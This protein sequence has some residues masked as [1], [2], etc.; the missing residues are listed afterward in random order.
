MSKTEMSNLIF[1]LVLFSELLTTFVLYTKFFLDDDSYSIFSSVT[2]I[3][4]R[5]PFWIYVSLRYSK[6]FFFRYLI[7]VDNIFMLGLLSIVC[8]YF[9][10]I[11][12]HWKSYLA[13]VSFT[14]LVIFLNTNFRV[15]MA[16]V[17]FSKLQLLFYKINR[18][19]AVVAY[20]FLACYNVA[21]PPSD[22][23]AWEKIKDNYLLFVVTT[24][25]Y[26]SDFVFWISHNDETHHL[27][28]HYGKNHD[29]SSTSEGHENSLTTI[30]QNH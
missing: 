8:Y 27:N 18:I 23:E 20:V 15:M 16:R 19:I 2:T 17:N 4:I 26:Y 3:G 12:S 22:H 13:F 24:S 5:V 28:I 9:F 1:S 7:L 25:V 6:G 11:T 14:L 29:G 21:N 10:I 30:L